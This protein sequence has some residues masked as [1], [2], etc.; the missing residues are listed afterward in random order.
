MESFLA[1]QIL[2]TAAE[3]RP[4]RFSECLRINETISSISMR[5]L[6]SKSISVKRASSYSR[7]TSIPRFLKI[8]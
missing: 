7:G 3:A 8:Y 1:E 4:E 5:P 2:R 6:L